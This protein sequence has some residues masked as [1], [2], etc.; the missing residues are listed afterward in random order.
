[1]TLEKQRRTALASML[2][3]L[4]DEY[5]AGKPGRISPPF[6]PLP[7]R[8]PIKTA[9][10]RLPHFAVLPA[11]DFSL[12]MSG[13]PFTIIKVQFHPGSVSAPNDAKPESRVW[14]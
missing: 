1:M 12:D 2:E 5:H 13:P 11:R 7:R 4:Y 8:S 6:L 3:P 10:V 14:V 9:R